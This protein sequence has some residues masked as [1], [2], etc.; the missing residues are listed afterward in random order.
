MALDG[1][2]SLIHVRVLVI[3]LYFICIIQTTDRLLSV[4]C[5][6]RDVMK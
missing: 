4:I 6:A 3:S 5:C 2:S 1:K